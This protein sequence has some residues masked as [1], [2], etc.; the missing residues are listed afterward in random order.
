MEL[1]FDRQPPRLDY[2][3]DQDAFHEVTSTCFGKS[4]LFTDQSE[5]SNEDIIHA[6][7]GQSQIEAAF[8]CMKDPHFVSWSPMFHWTDQKIRVH[9][10]YCVLALTL[11]S[12]LHREVSRSGLD[13]SI[14][15]LLQALGGIQEV[16][17]IYP[18]SARRKNSIVLR[19]RTPEQQQLFDL[20]DLGRYTIASR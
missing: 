11:T 9:A 2:A 16:A 4:I 19:K 13:L 10:F 20:L 1:D 5:W 14:P 6:Y 17:V 7:R 18:E 3:I 15:G 12:L 8:R